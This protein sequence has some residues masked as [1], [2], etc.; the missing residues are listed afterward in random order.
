MTK[1]IFTF[2]GVV[3]LLYVIV[4]YVLTYTNNS[5]T[6]ESEN[7]KVVLKA[8]KEEGVCYV[9]YTVNLKDGVEEANF[10]RVPDDNPSIIKLSFL[11]WM[12][13]PDPFQIYVNRDIAI[14]H[15]NI[16]IT[17]ETPYESTTS[18][19]RCSSIGWN[20]YVFEIDFIDEE[21]MVEA[22]VVLYD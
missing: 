8:R 22:R 14:P 3:I 16:L 6:I 21:T 18:I 19:A 1:K 12:G 15:E 7:F 9:D 17:S 13:F 10:A 11:F 4:G 2:L 5:Q 20:R